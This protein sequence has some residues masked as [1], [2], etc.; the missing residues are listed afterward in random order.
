[1]TFNNVLNI[2]SAKAYEEYSKRPNYQQ[3]T[4][5]NQDKQM[6][7]MSK[8]QTTVEMMSKVSTKQFWAMFIIGLAAIIV[9]IIK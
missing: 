4:V 8:M 9:A 5:V 6:E 2:S 7:I 1:M 3:Q